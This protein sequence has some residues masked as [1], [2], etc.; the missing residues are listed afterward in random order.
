MLNGVER[1]QDCLRSTGDIWLIIKS[2]L[3]RIVGHDE[4]FDLFEP[5]V[6]QRWRIRRDGDGRQFFLHAMDRLQAPRFHIQD[7]RL[8]SITNSN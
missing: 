3:S 8:H 6:G 2:G 5:G 7:L 4:G 1:R